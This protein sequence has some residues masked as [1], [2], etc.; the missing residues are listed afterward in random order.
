MSVK[1]PRKNLK[2]FVR[3]ILGRWFNFLALADYSGIWW[4]TLPSLRGQ[5]RVLWLWAGRLGAQRAV[6]Q[7]QVCLVSHTIPIIAW[8]T[9]ELFLDHSNNRRSVPSHSN[10][11]S[12][13]D[14]IYKVSAHFKL[15]GLIK[16]KRRLGAHFNQNLLIPNIYCLS[17]LFIIYF[18]I[19]IS[20]IRQ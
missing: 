19:P 5:R 1:T 8:I 12:Y 20:L 7:C 6:R 4:F 17:Q 18:E 2:G 3:W 13:N 11:F 10:V 9:R 16:N 14:A 15:T